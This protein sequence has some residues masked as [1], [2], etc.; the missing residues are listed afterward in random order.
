MNRASNP[1]TDSQRNPDEPTPRDATT[2]ADVTADPIVGRPTHPLAA[3]IGAVVLGGASGAAVGSV[4]GPIGTFVGAAIGAIG[5]ALGGDAIASSFDEAAE[6]EHWRNHYAKR[7]YVPQ[8]ARFADYG[9]AYRYGAIS[10]SRLAGRDFQD[11]E[12]QLSA[13]WEGARGASAL[14]WEQAKHAARDA[15]ERVHGAGSRRHD[16]DEA[17]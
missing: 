9:P 6:D 8:N 11:V 13:G 4:A 12:S 10:Y 7:P 16:A 14:Q 3:G 2:P 17:L 1:R 15:W 5:G